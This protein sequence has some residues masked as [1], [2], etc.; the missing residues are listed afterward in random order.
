MDGCVCCRLHCNWNICMII[1]PPLF[2][3]S[4]IL[5]LTVSLQETRAASK[6]ITM[7]A[8]F[9]A[10]TGSTVNVAVRAITSND[11]IKSLVAIFAFETLAMPFVSLSEHH[12]SSKDSAAAA[13]TTLTG[14]CFNGCSVS[15][16]C[17]WCMGNT[18]EIKSRVAKVRNQKGS[19][20]LNYWIQAY[21][22]LPFKVSCIAH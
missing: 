7:W 5:P 20:K 10:V 14:W 11:W 2:I 9:L 1:M 21:V 3:F 17:L 12:F 15:N 19:T 18:E 4:Q 13:G 16:R 6:T 8:P 22:P